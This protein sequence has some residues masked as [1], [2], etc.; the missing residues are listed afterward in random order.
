MEAKL[1][2]SFLKEFIKVLKTLD[3]KANIYDGRDGFYTKTVDPKQYMLAEIKLPA[4]AFA[5][6][7]PANEKFNY[8]LTYFVEFLSLAEP[9]QLISLRTNKINMLELR[10][11]NLVRNR[12]FNEP[13]ADAKIP[14]L[15]GF[16]GHVVIP[17]EEL[18]KAGKA[19]EH[20]NT[21]LIKLYLNPSEFKLYAEDNDYHGCVDY[22]DNYGCLG[23]VEFKLPHSLSPDFHCEKE[24][25]SSFN[26]NLLVEL[27]NVI[28]CKDVKFWLGDNY[29]L[30]AEFSLSSPNSKVTY[31]IAPYVE[32]SST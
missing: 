4:T 10:M 9:E 17:V 7:K 3:D 31:L 26:K 14:K 24:A 16:L 30:K 1:K 32:N 28:P 18:R 15:D 11:G 29:A 25:H 27:I 13:V 12:K 19:T 5:E 21:D 22:N 2:A 6:Y 8:D 23:Y 20:L